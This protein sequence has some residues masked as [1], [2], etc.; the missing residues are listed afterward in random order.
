MTRAIKAQF[1]R[2]ATGAMTSN[3]INL[4]PPLKMGRATYQQTKE[5][6]G[7]SNQLGPKSLSKIPI[8]VELETMSLL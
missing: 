4:M 7:H 8:R 5:A 6:L 1:C 2:W 3:K